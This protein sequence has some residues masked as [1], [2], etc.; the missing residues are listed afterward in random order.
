VIDAEPARHIG[1]LVRRAVV[2][3]E[4]FD[5]VEPGHAAWEVA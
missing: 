2:D 5:R 4:P 1:G 3:D